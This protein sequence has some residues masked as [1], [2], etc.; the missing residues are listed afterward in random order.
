MSLYNKF[1]ESSGYDVTF[2]M[3][4][5][6][7]DKPNSI[8]SMVLI[9]EVADR[10]VILVDDMTDT[11]GTLLKAS[12][13]LKEKGATRVAALVTHGILSGEAPSK[14]TFS[15]TL[16][17]LVISDSMHH[18]SDIVSSPKIEIVSCAKVFARAISS[19]ANGDS[20]EKILER[21]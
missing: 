15:E 16:D 10:S 17:A 9:G 8:E 6:R 13:I 2:A 7:R 12:E 19:V 14:V 11:A 1:L 18:S 5:K 3:M 4:S 20:M 21:N